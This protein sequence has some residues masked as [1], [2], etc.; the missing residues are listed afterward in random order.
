M[1]RQCPR[2]C[3]PAQKNEKKKPRVA[4]HVLPLRPLARTFLFFSFF[5]PKPERTDQEQHLLVGLIGVGLAIAG[6]DP[7]LGCVMEQHVFQEDLDWHH[8]G[9][10]ASEH[11]D[12][13][14]CLV[15]AG[16]AVLQC[17]CKQCGC[18]RARLTNNRNHGA[19]L[20]FI[21]D[22]IVPRT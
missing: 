9:D 8:D 6:Y 18:K 3:R 15:S 13:S 20:F 21:F 16:C 5:L 12:E 14:S 1:V 19:T 4:A 10:R 11:R 2:R 22:E 17:G 7:P